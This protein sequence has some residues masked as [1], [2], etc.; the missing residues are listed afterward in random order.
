MLL[1]YYQSGRAS[2]TEIIRALRSMQM[3]SK[4]NALEEDYCRQNESGNANIFPLLQGVFKV[5]GELLRLVAK[6]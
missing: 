3:D 4:A 1:A 5:T 2:W 6:T